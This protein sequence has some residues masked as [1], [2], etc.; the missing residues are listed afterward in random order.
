MKN[1]WSTSLDLPLFLVNEWDRLKRTYRVDFYPAL[2]A[3]EGA[4]S[5]SDW[6]DFFGATRDEPP[7]AKGIVALMMG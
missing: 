2:I 7:R 6:L 3:W 4:G 5:M 1:R